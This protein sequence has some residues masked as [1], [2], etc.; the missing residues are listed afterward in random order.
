MRCQ[1]KIYH[2]ENKTTNKMSHRTI[3]DSLN[4]MVDCEWLATDSPQADELSPCLN[5]IDI[6][7]VKK[8]C[9]NVSF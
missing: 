9:S 6:N 5:T 8:A 3:C 1:I 4:M 7:K 2:I